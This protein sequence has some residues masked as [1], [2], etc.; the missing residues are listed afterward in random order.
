MLQ[1][2]A[3]HCPLLLFIICLLTVG[4]AVLFD[5]LFSVYCCDLL[6]LFVLFELAHLFAFTDYMLFV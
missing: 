1:L 3:G 4:S 6:K 2:F 5:V